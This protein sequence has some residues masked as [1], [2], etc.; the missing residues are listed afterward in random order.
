MP[1]PV[2]IDCTMKVISSL[3]LLPLLKKN[4]PY[5]LDRV[6][7]GYQSYS[8]YVTKKEKFT[9][10]IRN[11]LAFRTVLWNKCKAS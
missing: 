2:F 7:V 4:Y 11:S 9:P 3:P 1:I 10:C 5:S 8:G 6:L